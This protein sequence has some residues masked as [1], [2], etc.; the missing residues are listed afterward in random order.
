MAATEFD[1]IRSTEEAITGNGNPIKLAL[2]SILDTEMP[3]VGID[4]Q[5][6]M[7]H[8]ENGCSVVVASGG[9]WSGEILNGDRLPFK[10]QCGKELISYGSGLQC[11]KRAG[12]CDIC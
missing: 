11:E 3:T 9:L 5:R 4:F 2:L 10:N 12:H 1:K 8:Q 6:G 7:V